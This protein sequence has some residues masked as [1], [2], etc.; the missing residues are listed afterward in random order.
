M[1]SEFAPYEPPA[2]VAPDTQPRPRPAPATAATPDPP[3]WLLWPARVVAVSV[4]LPV[5]LVWEVLVSAARSVSRAG[6]ALVALLGRAGLALLRPVLALLAAVGRV[7]ELVLLRPVAAVMRLLGRALGAVGRW[8]GAV[9]RAGLRGLGRLLM[10]PL[11]LLWRWALRPVLT[12]VAIGLVAVVQGAWHFLLRPLVRAIHAA[13]RALG[14][15][16]AWPWHLGGRALRVLGGVLAAPFGWT[17]RHVL[18]P[19]GHAA[20]AAWR[21]CVAG[22]ARAVRGA[23]AAARAS[24]REAGAQVRQQVSVLLGRRR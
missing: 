24:V 23:A 14:R 20:R 9:L 3:R 13:A 15:G 11:L 16:L 18:T 17:Y 4:V 21:A 22:P 5:R 19:V 2:V 8:L 10:A 7:V 6:G 1:V 12:A